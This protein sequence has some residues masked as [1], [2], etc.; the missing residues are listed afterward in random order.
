MSF[1]SEIQNHGNTPLRTQTRTL[2]DVNSLYFVSSRTNMN[3]AFI[4]LFKCMIK[5]IHV[6]G[7]RKPLTWNRMKNTQSQKKE[8]E[9][10]SKLV[11]QNQW[12]TKPKQS[13]WECRSSLYIIRRVYYIWYYWIIRGIVR[14]CIKKNKLRWQNAISY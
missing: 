12:V 8:Y 11:V 1:L 13:V 2:L 14:C 9:I 10:K 6:P 7:T 5:N 4:K 3:L